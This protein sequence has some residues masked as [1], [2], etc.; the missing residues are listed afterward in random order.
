MQQTS[1]QHPVTTSPPSWNALSYQAS[2]DT[3]SSYP[4]R[5]EER[6]ESPYPQV[7]T[8]NERSGI[9]THTERGDRAAPVLP[10]AKPSAAYPPPSA[11]EPS[12]TYSS[13]SATKPSTYPLSPAKPH[14]LPPLPLKQQSTS[15]SLPSALTSAPH[16]ASASTSPLS[17]PAP[18]LT[19]SA[20]NQMNA[21]RGALPS[22]PHAPSRGPTFESP[23]PSRADSGLVRSRADEQQG[24]KDPSAASHRPPATLAYA[25][26]TTEYPRQDTFGVPHT[27]PISPEHFRATERY[28]RQDR[29]EF[30]AASH[31]PTVPITS[32]VPDVTQYQS[33]PTEDPIQRSESSYRGHSYDSTASHLSDTGN[34][35]KNI[36]QPLNTTSSLDRREL[37]ITPPATSVIRE[38]S[39]SNTNSTCHT[40]ST[41]SANYWSQPPGDSRTHLTSDKYSIVLADLDC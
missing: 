4:F 23:Y 11:T 18:L 22:D 7:D 41:S 2:Q 5:P 33:A 14:A 19:T 10:S 16:W 28:S 27:A 12:A 20:S 17:S 37:H 34:S 24:L 40:N 25:P 8:R 3:G 35:R 6:N 9:R 21:Q 1:Q 38:T 31:R 29:K 39:I 26:A 32:Y 13:Q 30:P 36:E 15:T